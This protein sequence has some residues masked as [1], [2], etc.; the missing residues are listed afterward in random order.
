MERRRLSRLAA[1]HLLVLAS[2]LCMACSQQSPRVSEPTEVPIIGGTLISDLGQDRPAD[3]YL[4]PAYSGSEATPLLVLLHGYGASGTL[5]EAYFK[6]APAVARHG[7]IYAVPDGTLDAA[8]QRFWNATEA[9]CNFDNRDVDD[10]A[11]LIGLIDEIESR[12][13]LDPGRI[14]LVGYSNGG[15]MALRLACQYPERF[16]AVVSIAGAQSLE[17]SDCQASKGVHFLQIHGTADPTIHYKGGHWFGNAYP[18]ARETVET[19]V[20]INECQPVPV[21]LEPVNLDSAIP[22]PETTRERWPGCAPGTS[23]ALW[24]IRSG[25]HVPALAT[26]FGDTLLDYLVELGEDRRWPGD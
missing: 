20:A 13:A 21:T 26:S 5:Q 24:T 25:G 17:R 10:T 3:L 18:G 1:G 4:P 22:G 7:F 11:Y 14:F 6:L 19:W 15:F 8:G 2:A 23:A 9:C 12:Y 16:A